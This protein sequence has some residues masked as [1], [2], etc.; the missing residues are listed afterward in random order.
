MIYS[1]DEKLLEEVIQS[2][3]REQ[4]E[5]RLDGTDIE[6]IQIQKGREKDLSLANITIAE[7]SEPTDDE[8]VSYHIC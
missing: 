1:N 5:N 4:E 7:P 8:K 6:P 2:L 3:I